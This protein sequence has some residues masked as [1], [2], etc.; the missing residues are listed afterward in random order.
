MKEAS[1][2]GKGGVTIEGGDQ[3]QRLLRHQSPVRPMQVRGRSPPRF[4]P[5]GTKIPDGPPPV[6]DGDIPE[7]PIPH[8]ENEAWN[9]LTS[10]DTKDT[11]WTFVRPVGPTST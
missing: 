2:R 1:V 10:Q 9:T 4:T 3:G 8:V 6:D 11:D 5:Q 7:F